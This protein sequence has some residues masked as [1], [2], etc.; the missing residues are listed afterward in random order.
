MSVFLALPPDQWVGHNGLAFAVRDAFPVSPG[1]TLV[2]PKRLVATW[3]EATESEQQAILELVDNVKALLDTEYEPDGYNVGFNSGAAAGQTIDHL[4]LHVIP[5]YAGDMDDPRGGVR[6]VIPSR[7]NYLVPDISTPTLITPLG[8]P[9]RGHLRLELARAFGREDLDRIDLV[10]SFVKRSG[11]SL[12]ARHIDTALDRGAT[13]RLLTTDYLDVTDAGALGFFLDRLHDIPDGR[14]QARVFS[15]PTTS[16]HPKAY[17]FTSSGGSPGV[18]FVGSS[19]L[20]HSGIAAG[21]EWNIQ[22]S[23]TKRLV[24]EFNELWDDERSIELTDEW[25]TSYDARQRVRLQEGQW[26]PDDAAFADERH[27]D[28]ITPWSV[29]AEALAALEATR[30]DGHQAGL[31]VMATGLGK[32]W[33]AAF[34]STRPEFRRVLFVAHREEILTQTRDV[35]RRIRP[36]G[37]FGMFI[38]GDH[39]RDGNVVFAS[40]QSLQLHLNEFPPDSFDYIVVDEFHHAAA[41]SYRK[42]IGHFRPRFLLGLTATPERSDNADLLAL[43]GDNLVYECDLVE[44]IG[45]ELLS[46]FRYRAIPDVADYE[47]I[48]WKNGRFDAE[49]LTNQI[50][51]QER[52]HQVFD[53]W[54]A[55]G[56]GQRRALGFCCTIEHADFMAEYFRSRGTAAVAVHSGPTSAPRAASL[57][58]LEAGSV[59]VVFTVDLFNEGVDIPSIDLV[60]ML[61]PTESSIVFLQQLGRGLRRADGKS[62]LDVIDLVGNHRGFLLKAR[63]LAKLAGRPAT[64]DRE[65]VHAVADGLENDTEGNCLPAGCSIVVAPE[66][67][68]L[69]QRMLGPKRDEDLLLELVRAWTDEHEGRRPTAMEIALATG[70][71][72]QLK[73]QGGWYG[74]LA[75]HGLLDDDESAVFARH[76]EFFDW[77]EH[78]SYSKSYKLITLLALLQHDGLRTGVAVNDVA[79]TSRWMIFRDN[80]LISDLADARSAFDNVFSPTPDEWRRYWRRNPIAAMT[81][82]TRGAKPRFNIEADTLICSESVDPNRSEAF[83]AM[84]RELVEYRLH[85]YLAGRSAKRVGVT[86]RPLRSGKEIDATFSVQTTGLTATSVVIESAGGTKGAE[87]AR[88]LQYVEGFDLVLSRLALLRS[89]LL[90]AS[91]DTAR[92][93]TMPLADRRLAPP[94]GHP[95]PI[96]LATVGVTELR[97]A[98]LQSMAKVGQKPGAKGGGNQR[99]RTRL[100]IATPT[101]MTASE[102]A[103]FL[104]TAELPA[105]EGQFKFEASPNP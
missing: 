59:P 88:N 48:P 93:K 83:D 89:T 73:R 90:D 85:R 68:D 44:G 101:P 35:Y 77:V 91:I 19:N 100:V 36:S 104:M 3:W 28:P 103:E 30:L 22:T 63:I 84:T 49:E 10:V 26:Q 13:I 34:D 41:A 60:L 12:F 23:G 5:R 97:K 95:Y 53:E 8:D 38:G 45:R 78:G 1:H 98:L 72:L 96:D 57:E 43:C 39:D 9:A 54:S 40:V 76:A 47:H 37:T 62:H 64:T 94:P 50:A 21:V 74:F 25:L 80:D 66:V 32:T 2:I 14:L 42:V 55:A 15:D 99:K 29:Q 71:G 4:H 102:L 16:F 46:P 58:E 56:G 86:H 65:A 11:I 17:I 24:E 33:L 61:R 27:E 105:D 7:G 75:Q 92:T 67:V 70:Q 18:A 31:V 51:T 87:S 20:T 79:A 69:F 52:A 6:H 81:S 82:S